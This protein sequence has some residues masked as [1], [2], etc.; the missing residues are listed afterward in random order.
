MTRSSRGARAAKAL[1]LIA[2]AG[3]AGAVLWTRHEALL[4]LDWRR[5]APAF[6]AA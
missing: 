3:G 2:A 1:V 6:A 5:A 4:E